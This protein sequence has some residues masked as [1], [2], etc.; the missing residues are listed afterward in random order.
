VR[1]NRSNKAAKPEAA[2]GE[3]PA[4]A[5]ELRAEVQEFKRRRILEEAR[6]LFFEQGYEATT[7]D[8]IAESLNVTKPFLY[9]YFRNKS[10]IL[11]AICEIGITESMAAQEEVLAMDLSP[12]EKLRLIVERVTSIVIRDQKYVVVYNR[13][14]KNLEAAEQKH[15]ID[16]RKTFDQRLAQ[17]LEEGNAAGEF[18]VDAPRMLSVSISGMLTWVATWYRQRAAY[19]ATDV[20]MHMIQTVERMVG[21]KTRTK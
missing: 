13:E 17:L 5:P 2:T 15:L 7:L 1:T 8:A 6:E 12:A 11:N 16:L 20:G 19:T 18:A 4:K 3:G 9:S 10:E 14:E 21:Q